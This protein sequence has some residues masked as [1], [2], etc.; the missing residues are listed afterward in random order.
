VLSPNHVRTNNV[1]YQR[2]AEESQSTWQS[3]TA[4]DLCLVG[5]VYPSHGESKHQRLYSDPH[6]R[7][8]VTIHH[9]DCMPTHDGGCHRIHDKG[10]GCAAHNHTMRLLR[11]THQA[12]LRGRQ[13]RA[14]YKDPNIGRAKQDAI[15]GVWLRTTPRMMSKALLQLGKHIMLLLVGNKSPLWSPTPWAIKG[16]DSLHLLTH[17]HQ[18]VLKQYYDQHY[19]GLVWKAWIS[20]I[21]CLNPLFE[22]PVVHHSEWIHT[23]IPSRTQILLSS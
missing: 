23:R 14:R 22:P 17:T 18:T 10:R 4:Y 16:Q 2:G 13:H 3:S 20:M 15:S 1:A 11:G 21:L 7:K 9:S 12:P 5:L 8:D 19:T 6:T